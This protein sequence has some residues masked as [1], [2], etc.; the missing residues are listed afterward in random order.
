MKVLI[1]RLKLLRVYACS[2][3]NTINILMFRKTTKKN[4]LL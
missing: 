2:Q 1:M 3:Q 4:K